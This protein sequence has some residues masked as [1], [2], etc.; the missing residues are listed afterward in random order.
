VHSC[1]LGLFINSTSFTR[2]L[3]G[4]VTSHH[5]LSFALFARAVSLKGVP[6]HGAM[7]SAGSSE[8]SC[9]DP[10]SSLRTS[11]HLLEPVGRAQQRCEIRAH[12]L[13][14]ADCKLKGI[15]HQAL[16]RRD[17][18]ARRALGHTGTAR[19]EG[20][21]FRRFTPGNREKTVNGIRDLHSRKVLTP[22]SSMRRPGQPGR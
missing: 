13:P 2:A 18:L 9:F 11:K 7:R 10:K 22:S 4:S 1:W 17:D 8:P 16:C 14:A 12:I 15:C 20:C 19:A 6:C 5:R 21:R 3:N